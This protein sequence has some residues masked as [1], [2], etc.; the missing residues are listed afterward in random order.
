M[1][2]LSSLFSSTTIMETAVKGAYNSIDMAIYTDEE[3]ALA[4]QKTQEWLLEYQKAT[5]PQ[6][7]SRRYIAVMI[8]ALWVVLIVLTAIL[9]MVG[10]QVEATFIL[11]LLTDVVMQPFSIIVAFY[12]LSHVVGKI[13][14]GK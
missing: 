1:G 4:Q 12:F 10:M 3:R 14:G 7:L 2:F 9:K 6:N 8:T 13:K 11:T 5:A